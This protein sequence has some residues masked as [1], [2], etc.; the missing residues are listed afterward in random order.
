METPDAFPAWTNPD[1]L[2]EFLHTRMAPYE[3]T[4]SDVRRGIDD[5]LSSADAPGRGG[6]VLLA[7]RGGALVGAL[8]MRKT[9]MRGYVPPNLLL[10]V[11]VEPALRGRGIG[12]RLVERGIAACQGPV[13][14]H[15]EPDNPA[16][17]LYERVGFQQPYVEMRIEAP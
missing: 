2:T 5:A 3:D 4:R 10:F 8:V 12:R 9:G 7:E 15:V 11:G 14:L 13:K 17:R 6:F 16:R 1:E